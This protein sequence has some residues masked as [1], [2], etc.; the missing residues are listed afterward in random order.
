MAVAYAGYTGCDGCRALEFDMLCLDMHLEVTQRSANCWRT[1]SMHIHTMDGMKT[2]HTQI[3]QNRKS[4]LCVCSARGS[5]ARARAKKTNANTHNSIPVVAGY[6]LPSICPCWDGCIWG[7]Q[8]WGPANILF[9]FDIKYLHTWRWCSMGLLLLLPPAK[10]NK[11]TT[12]HSTQPSEWM[13][14]AMA[15]C[16]FALAVMFTS[17]ATVRSRYTFITLIARITRRA[18][19]RRGKISS[20]TQCFI[21]SL[22]AGIFFFV[23]LQNA[24]IL[25]CCISILYS[26]PL[27]VRRKNKKQWCRMKIAEL[28]EY[29]ARHVDCWVNN[30]NTFDQTTFLFSLLIFL[31]DWKISLSGE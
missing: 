8:P 11:H 29:G 12:A 17:V 23:L 6:G 15:C 26:P 27:F 19:K 24:R 28:F 9:D 21:Y 25:C 14:M 30:A 1:H 20:T 7:K 13:N 16:Y 31:F 18:A 2:G 4:V 3:I 10:H 5:C 22:S